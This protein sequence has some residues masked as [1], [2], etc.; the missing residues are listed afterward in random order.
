MSQSLSDIR[1]AYDA[2]AQPYAEKFLDELQHK[3]LDRELLNRFA[4]SIGNGKRVIDLGCGPGHTTAHLASLGLTPTG[5]DLS[6]KMIAK[7]QSLFPEL[8]FTVGDFLELDYPGQSFAG[9]LAFYCIVHLQRDQLLSAFLEMARVLKPDGLL[10]LSFHIGL[11][12]VFVP[13][14]LE[15]GAA[16]EFFPFPIDVVVAALAAAGFSKIE[17]ASRQPYDTEY[18]SQRCYVLARVRSKE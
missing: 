9:C 6:P 14:F 3:P 5:V 13:D 18:P 12:P 10:L 11:E 2:A 8:E 4:M 1:G 16:L 15:S 17:V 7:A